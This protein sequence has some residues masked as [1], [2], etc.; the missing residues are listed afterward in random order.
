[1]AW[2]VDP[3]MNVLYHTE[4][5]TKTDTIDLTCKLTYPVSTGRPQTIDLLLTFMQGQDFATYQKP[6]LS[7]A[8]KTGRRASRG[9][10]TLHSSSNCKK[11][12]K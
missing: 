10:V 6:I 4:G 2:N 7:K 3:N 8:Y 5:P 9:Q 11:A 12:D 1:M